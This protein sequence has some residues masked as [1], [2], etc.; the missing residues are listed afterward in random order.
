MF[1]YH[2][3]LFPAVL[4]V[5]QIIFTILLGFHSEYRYF[6]I[7]DVTN[8]EQ[9]SRRLVD[10]YYPM[11]TDIHVMLFVGFG[12]MLTF[13]RRYF[14]DTVGFHFILCT[15]TIEWSLII[16]GYFFDWNSTTRTFIIDVQSL[17]MADFVA[18]TTLTS[19]GTVLGKVNGIQ[20][21][22]M[23]FCEVPF[24]VINQFIGVRFFCANDPGE[25]MYVHTF[26]KKE[27]RN[28]RKEKYSSVFISRCIFWLSGHL[29]SVPFMCSLSY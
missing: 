8:V 1:N 2:T 24:Q 17:V 23:A 19:M 12:F 16:R 3:Y 26:G 5:S 15:F 4:F 20:L 14:Y 7:S 22:I 25:S 21:I 13:L 29:C 10:F 27:K 6:P 28:D 18:A 11:F 9:S